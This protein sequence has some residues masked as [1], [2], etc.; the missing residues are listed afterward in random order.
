MSK[1]KYFG[2]YNKVPLNIFQV[3][4]N[5]DNISNHIKIINPEFNY[6]YFDE[7]D[8][9]DFIYNNYPDYIYN[10]YKKLIPIDYKF[11]LW[12]YCIL[13]K[14]GGIYIDNKFECNIKLINL[15]D[16]NFF[17]SDRNYYY[18][19]FLINTDFIISIPNNPIFKLAITDIINNIKLNYYGIDY[20]FPTG[21][22]L[23][24]KIFSSNKFK[25][26]L[27]YDNNNILFKNKIILKTKENYKN[28]NYS[29]L[30]WLSKNIYVKNQK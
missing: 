6:F 21:S 28:N 16:N 17:V 24:G 14:Y 22:G 18:N 15:I 23:L 19:K 13:Y 30:L 8:C 27:Y 9:D 4:I 10:A 1:I 5:K 7:K 2:I 29:K 20:T 11:D 3:G 26:L 25:T 12:K